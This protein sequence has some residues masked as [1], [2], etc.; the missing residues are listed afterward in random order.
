MKQFFVVLF[1]LSFG[2][3]GA[4]P[5]PTTPES[6]PPSI[7]SGAE[8]WAGSAL[9]LPAGSPA[10]AVAELAEIL[11]AVGRLKAW[12]VAEPQMLGE[13]GETTAQMVELM[14]RGFAAQLGTDPLDPMAWSA[15]GVDVTR[16]ILLGAYPLDEESQ[17]WV[18]AV[19]SSVRGEL[20]LGPGV[21]PL[22][23]LVAAEDPGT[24]FGEGANARVARSVA[25]MMPLKG[26]RV[27]VPVTNVDDFLASTD[28]FA[29]V[30]E[31][32]RL[33][34]EVSAGLGVGGVTRVYVA[35]GALSAFAVRMHGNDAVLDVLLPLLGGPFSPEVRWDYL[36]RGLQLPAGRPA[37]PRS[38][39]D[40]SVSLSFDQAGAARLVR[41]LR[42]SDRLGAIADAGV[43]Q[44][45]QLLGGVVM[46][47]EAEALAWE[48]ASDEL[49]G[50]TVGLE[51]P[52]RN[53]S[54]IARFSTTIFG[55]RDLPLL[56]RVAPRPSLG[57]Q[58]RSAA[59]SV[60]LQSMRS[61]SWGRWF[62]D[63]TLG[64]LGALEISFIADV[65][66]ILP[67]LRTM[68]LLLALSGEKD[69]HS[70]IGSG[71]GP[72]VR[73][74][75]GIEQVEVVT[76][77]PAVREGEYP[78]VVMLAALGADASAEADNAMKAVLSAYQ[79][80]WEVER[81]EAPLELEAAEKSTQLLT[82]EAAPPLRYRIVESE[83]EKFLVAG[84]GIDDATF[85]SELEGLATKRGEEHVISARV[86]P[87]ALVGWLQD[88]LRSLD[89][90]DV[91]ILAQRLGPLLVSFSPVT[92]G[93]S[94]AV[95]LDIVLQSPLE[96]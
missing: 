90:I 88:S 14:W 36:K 67:G 23:T 47:V 29:E 18:N 84:V 74:L 82:F 8:S 26:V 59:V 58:D 11:D 42:Y 69:A 83:G 81:P 86:E 89:Q 6:Q 37:A 33:S 40:F 22:A 94:R 31:F 5:K 57:V 63:G 72:T 92:A 77:D 62:D 7:P 87:I 2:C 65:H 34:N 24:V 60:A 53:E 70:E 9:L 10:V 51:L 71:Y 1:L 16:P 20:D 15:R 64:E 91:D 50:Y 13:D 95:S 73:H 75:L 30:F 25:G 43:G 56:P 19:G 3:S 79:L 41:A 80:R 96:L 46:E 54:E 39:D 55:A 28:K 49:T 78:R 21:S 68:T 17:R 66:F 38:V 61:P 48:V 35:D 93:E 45:D 52:S 85:E 32:Q 76:L 12:L 4:P 44:R 27:V